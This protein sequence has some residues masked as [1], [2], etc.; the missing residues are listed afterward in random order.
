[1]KAYY[2][3]KYYSPAKK[4]TKAKIANKKALTEKCCGQGRL[5]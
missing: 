4:K 3:G 5:L 1:M 2:K